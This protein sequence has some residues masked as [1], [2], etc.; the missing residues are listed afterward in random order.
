[1]LK[2]KLQYFGHLMWSTDSFEKTLMLGNDWRQKENVMTEDEMIGRHHWLNGHEFE[3]T[4]GVGVG[5][6]GLACCD[7]WGRKESD[8]TERLNWTE[9]HSIWSHHF[10][11]N[12][13]GK[14]GS[15]DRFSFLGFQNDCSPEIKRHLL[16]GGKAM[17]NLDSALNNRDITLLTKVH[18]VK[19]KVFPAVMYK[20]ESWTVKKVECLRIDT[21]E[22]CC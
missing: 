20:C 11:V 15:S 12:R 5:Q 1:M 6:G 19:V 16:L 10:M 3:W 4:P 22:L 7:L 8:T 21:F 14:S 13:R 2:L 17:T 18:I 9:D